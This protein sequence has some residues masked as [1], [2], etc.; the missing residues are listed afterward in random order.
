MGQAAL[1]ACLFVFGATSGWAQQKANRLLP[2]YLT[3][4]PP[5]QEEG[6]RRLGA[7]RAQGISGD[8]FLRFEL[9]W[10]PRRGESRR[11][12]GTWWGT[13]NATGPLSRIHLGSEA[14]T[15]ARFL[16]QNGATARIWRQAGGEAPPALVPPQ[17][18]FALIVGTNLTAFDLQMPFTYWED[19]VYEGVTRI[20]GRPVHAFLLYPP[21]DLRPFVPELG[22]VRVYLDDQFGSLLQAI[23]LDAQENPTKSMTVLDLKRLG[24]QWIVKS[25]EVRDERTRD[26]TRF[27][28]VG[29]K[30]GLSFATGLFSPAALGE[31][32]APPADVESIN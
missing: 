5:D 25:V 24:E 26:K 16:V 3:V 19:W 22:G 13:Q 27:S 2:R 28:V 12:P 14:E 32:L 31:P 11:V 20:R 23:Q 10:L 9:T 29:A 8:Y 4:G 21:E 17:A 18:W 7:W 1:A 15:S 6:A 30:L